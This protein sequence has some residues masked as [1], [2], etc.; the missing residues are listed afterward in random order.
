MS[1]HDSQAPESGADDDDRRKREYRVMID[2]ALYVL[3]EPVV[4]GRQLLA[5]AGKV[6]LSSSRSTSS[7]RERSP[8]AL[9]WTSRWTCVRRASS[10]SSPFP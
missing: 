7:F 1:T 2:K 3:T 10:A 9:A 5:Q 8:S 6:P 4:T